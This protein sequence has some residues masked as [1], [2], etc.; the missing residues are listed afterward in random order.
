M[1]LKV[2]EKIYELENILLSGGSAYFTN[3]YKTAHVEQG[4]WAVIGSALPAELQ[5]YE[6][7]IT[8]VVNEHVEHGC[9]GGCL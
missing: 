1:V 4:G 3:D 6:E 5:K 8:K 2:D 9:C 7:D